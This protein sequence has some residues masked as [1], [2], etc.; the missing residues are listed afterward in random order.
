MSAMSSVRPVSGTFS[1]HFADHLVPHAKVL[2]DR[3][4]V[5]VPA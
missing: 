3:H 1:L 2:A 5:A 4:G